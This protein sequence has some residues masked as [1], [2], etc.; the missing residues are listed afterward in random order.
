VTG[1]SALLT[2]AEVA[3]AF[4]GFASVVTAFRRREHEGWEAGDVVRFRLM[5]SSSLSL[6]FFALLPFAIAFFGA[7]ERRVWS[8]ASVLLALY[9]AFFFFSTMRRAL[10]LAREAALNP[11]IVWSF[12][13]GAAVVFGLQVLNALAVVF[14]AELGPYFVGLMYLLVLA[15]VS[16]GR[17]LPMGS[18]AKDG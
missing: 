5:I 4:A 14:G 7:T 17:M 2:T 11:Y 6:V 8:L 13:V 1:E 16:F 12:L 18:S 3:V 9:M 10:P 15:G